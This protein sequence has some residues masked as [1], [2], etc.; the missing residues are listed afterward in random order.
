[1]Q[2]SICS[3]SAGT[4]PLVVTLILIS[5]C[6]D[7]TAVDPITGSIHVSITTIGTSPDS[8]GYVLKVDDNIARSVRA[9]DTL[10][11][12]GLVTSG[13]HKLQ[14]EGLASNCAPTQEPTLHVPAL[15]TSGNVT[16]FTISC[17]GHSVTPNFAGMQLLFV[18]Q[19][20]IFRTTIGSADAAV[21]LTTGDEPTWS[22]DGKRIAFVRGGDV[23]IMDGNGAFEHLIA[24]GSPDSVTQGY[25]AG[26]LAPAWSPDGGRLALY[27]GSEI[28]IVSVDDALTVDL[29]PPVSDDWGLVGSPTWSPDG[30]RIAFTSDHNSWDPGLPLYVGDVDGSKVSNAKRLN[31]GQGQTYAQPAWSPDGARIAVVECGSGDGGGDWDY[32]RGG[33]WRQYTCESAAIVVVN[34]D[35]SHGRTIAKTH[36]F[37]RPSW[38]PDG[39][40]ISFANTCWDYKCGSTLMYVTADGALT[41][42]ILDDAHSASLHK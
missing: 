26:R 24:T 40:A 4:I 34:A 18:R 21:A 1:M 33:G 29:V 37:A 10:T 32:D 20:Q 12:T 41:G 14:L 35:G 25:T 15:P 16:T 39:Q 30:K 9:N 28:V 22:P 7:S 27:S 17:I 31:P 6:K 38:A 3:R 19:G 13:D 5:A 36:G 11:V 2:L 23:Y 8:D 42:L